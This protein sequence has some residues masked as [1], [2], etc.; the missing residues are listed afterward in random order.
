MQLLAS[1]RAFYER[2]VLQNGKITDYSPYPKPLLLDIDNYIRGL[3]RV[4]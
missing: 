4:K 3:K 2:N 1:A